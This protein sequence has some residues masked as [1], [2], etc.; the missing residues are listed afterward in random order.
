MARESQR[1][2]KDSALRPKQKREALAR[3]A[4]QTPKQV[5]RALGAEAADAYFSSRGMDWLGHLTAGSAVLITENGVEPGEAVDPNM[6][7]TTDPVVPSE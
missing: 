4:S 6:G 1:T 7:T 2:V 3:L 5:G